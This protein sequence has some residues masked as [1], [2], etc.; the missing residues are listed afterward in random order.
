MY[1]LKKS[2]FLI[3]LPIACPFIITDCSVGT[4]M[5]RAPAYSNYGSCTNRARFGTSVA[6]HSFSRIFGVVR[7][8]QNSRMLKY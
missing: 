6:L 1:H 7:T 5:F 8:N 3:S 4:Q 2:S